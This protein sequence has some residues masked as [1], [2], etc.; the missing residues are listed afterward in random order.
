MK[1]KFV[2]R[3]PVCARLPMNL[4][5]MN[6]FQSLVVASPRSHARTF[7]NN[8]F[9]IFLRIFFIFDI[10][11]AEKFQNATLPT[12][13]SRTFSTFIWNFNDF[14]FVFVSMVPYGSESSK[15][16]S[17]YK[18][19]TFFPNLILIFPPIGRHKTTLRNIGILSFR[20]WVTFCGY[21]L[22]MISSPGKQTRSKRT[23]VR[24]AVFLRILSPLG[25]L[26]S[27]HGTFRQ[28]DGSWRAK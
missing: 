27:L 7:R 28:S 5:R 25:C 10:L 21:I 16:Y 3:A 1:S 23:G 9:E 4:Y 26:Y 18:S 22:Q 6:F 8:S 19:Q 13:C 11:W 14:F 20:F 17:P 24:S 15:R 12:N 2:R